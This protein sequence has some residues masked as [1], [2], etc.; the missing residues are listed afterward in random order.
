[1]AVAVRTAGRGQRPA[2]PLE[3]RCPCADP[4]M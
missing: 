3:G 1:M 2:S 4:G